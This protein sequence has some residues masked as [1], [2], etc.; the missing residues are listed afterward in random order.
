MLTR[1]RI[2]NRLTEL[3]KFGFVGGVAYIVDLG[4]FNLLRFG[5]G[6]ILDG[7][8]LTAKV[9]SACVATLVAWLGN[10]YWTFSAKRT[11]DSARELIQFAVV[12]VGGMAV[13]LICLWFSHYVL[14]FTSPLADNISA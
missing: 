2:V 10:R 11:T 14:G 3:F 6:E 8:P 1:E 13:A 12:N 4:L 7:S 9:I 5:P